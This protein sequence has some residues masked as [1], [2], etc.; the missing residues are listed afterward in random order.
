V[1][2]RWLGHAA[3]L[4]ECARPPARVLFD[5]Y[6]P[7]GFD[8]RIAHAPV[9]GPVYVVALTHHHA[10]HAHVTP[11][12]GTPRVVDRSVRVGGLAFR[13]VPAYHDAE[14]GAR[15]GLVRLVALE[16][17]GCRVVHLGDLGVPPTASQARR[18][19][20]PDVLFVPVGGT[21]TLDA[22]GGIAAVERLAPGVVV[23]IHYRTPGCTLPLA[24]VSDFL[25]RARARGWP[26]HT[27]G[28]SELTVEPARRDEPPRVVVLAPAR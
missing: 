7:G 9:P 16:A 22:A 15:M 17:D 19:G 3:V 2:V 18:L 27:P 10:D 4:A 6:E 14:R 24:D 1:I 26:V 12:L 5:P 28:G 11:A 20:R 13:V 8:G 23:P 21:Y 25:A